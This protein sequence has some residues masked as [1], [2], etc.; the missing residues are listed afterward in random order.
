MQI[1]G[2]LISFPFL[3]YPFQMTSQPSQVW[4]YFTKTT[5]EGQII[6]RCKLCKTGVFKLTQGSTS[7]MR[8]HLKA[9]H[10]FQ[11]ATMMRSDV[12]A[13]QDRK[14]AVSVLMLSYKDLFKFRIE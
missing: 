10:P 12:K 11:F 8:H 5:E 6:A 4:D 2:L 3:F 7:G 1:I 9:R 13:K 14:L